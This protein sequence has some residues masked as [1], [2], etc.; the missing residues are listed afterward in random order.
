LAAANKDLAD[1]AART[2]AG[3]SSIGDPGASAGPTLTTKITAEDAAILK[4]KFPFLKD[5]S[6]EYLQTTQLDVLIRAETTAY[7][8]REL[9]KGADLQRTLWPTTGTS[10]S[11]PSSRWWP[12]RTTDG[13][14]FT[15]LGSFPGL[16]A[17]PRRSGWR[18]GRS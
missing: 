14:S 4:K 12:G 5:Y 16:A 2:K 13:T 18:P 10:C 15:Q 11:P 1:E 8:L 3:F 6:N 7:K 17:R 9:E